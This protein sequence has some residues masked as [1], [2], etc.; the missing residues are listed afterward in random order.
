MIATPDVSKERR[1]RRK[2]LRQA[3]PYRHGLRGRIVV[4]VNV[5]RLKAMRD[6]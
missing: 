1:E 2:A 5:S 4:Q 6:A 3:W